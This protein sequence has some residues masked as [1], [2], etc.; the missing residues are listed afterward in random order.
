MSNKIYVCNIPYSMT[1]V[2]LIAI[3]SVYGQVLSATAVRDKVTDQAKG[4][5][6]IEMA[7]EEGKEAAIA[8]LNGRLISNRAIIVRDAIE[9][10]GP[11]P[12]P[13]ARILGDGICILCG[14]KHELSGYPEGPG[15]CAICAKIMGSVHYHKIKDQ[16][17]DKEEVTI[18]CV[19]R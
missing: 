9:K 17:A 18:E 16:E 2:D 4:F 10:V 19:A 13:R 3:F 5:G 15:I 6:F 14:E 1:S 8:G 11:L 12:R 7:T